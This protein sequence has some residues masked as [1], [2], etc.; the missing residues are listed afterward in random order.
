MEVE[1]ALYCRNKKF[2]I[3]KQPATGRNVDAAQ[4]PVTIPNW[5]LSYPD[6]QVT[7]KA[8]VTTWNAAADIFKPGERW[9][10][11]SVANVAR[12]WNLVGYASIFGETVDQNLRLK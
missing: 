3:G 10:N 12:R 5:R 8:L 1:D 9:S 4:I 2:R 11:R 7:T 6:L